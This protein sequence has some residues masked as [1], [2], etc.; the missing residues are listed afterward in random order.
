MENAKLHAEEKRQ[1]QRLQE[2]KDLKKEWD[3]ET[4]P[5]MREIVPGLFI[6]NVRASYT[7][8]ILQKNSI[9]AM[10]SLS[11]ALW[12]FWGT[13]TRNAGIPAHR[14]KW[15]QC[16]DSST[17]DLLV[18]MNDICDFIDEM[19]SPFL[20]SSSTLPIEHEHELHSKSHDGSSG[21]LLVH[22]DRARSRSPTIV[23]AY[24]MRKYSA[25]LGDALKFVQSKQK[26]R[27]NPNFMRQLQVWE[28]VGYDI[29]EDE[30]K[31]VPKAAYQAFLA[32]RAAL[33][34]EKG[35]AGNEPL[36]PLHLA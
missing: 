7:R 19:A 27:P 10:V 3:P 2:V 33:L 36:A 25:T 30:Q 18:Y 35:L 11:T 4:V 31:T 32:D 22:C 29:W 20:Q 9:N 8:D 5:Q 13:R 24:L 17:Q 14:H 26:I 16:A 15:V 34:K 1:G 28:E 12:C 6:G 23:I 21:A